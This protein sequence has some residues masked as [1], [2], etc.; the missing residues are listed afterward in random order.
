M[1]NA[2]IGI[3]LCHHHLEP[4]SL[5]QASEQASAAGQAGLQANVLEEVNRAVAGRLE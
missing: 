1:A 5:L 3:V 4:S 2:N